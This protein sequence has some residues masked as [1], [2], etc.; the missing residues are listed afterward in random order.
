MDITQ[1]R[2]KFTEYFLGL[3]YVQ[4]EPSK[5]VPENDPS[6]LYTT[7]GMQQFKNFYTRPE[8]APASAIITTQPVMRTSDIAE[9]GDDTHLTM[10]EMLG[11]FRFGYAS[12]FKMKQDALQEA[13]Q[14]LT[15]ELNIEP[16]RLDFN[17]FAGDGDI[18][19]DTESEGILRSLGVK[20]RKSGREDTFW[21]PTGDEGPCGPAPEVYLD[22]VEIGTIV[23]NQYYQSAD[24]KIR[25]LE[26][27]GLDVG[28]GLERLAATLQGKSSIWEIEPFL[29]WTEML[30][31]A[32]KK[33]ARLIVDHL[34]AVIFV[35]SAGV[36]PGKNG[37]EYIPRRLLARI[38]E[39][40][41]NF[42]PDYSFL[43]VNANRLGAKISAY[44]LQA[45]YKLLPWR[46]TAKSIEW[47]II[48]Y[49][50]VMAKFERE[51]EG[52]VASNR[53][54]Q[55]SAEKF[56]F[57]QFTA[58]GVPI[59]VVRQK[60]ATNEV[61]LDEKHLAELIEKHQATS[62]SGAVGIFKGGLADHEA[63]TVKHHTTHHLLLAALR[64]VLGNSIV[65]RGSNV[66]SE[67]LRLDFNFD[68]K[69]T[70]EELKKVAAIVNEKIKAD[71]P[72]VCEEMTK[73][74]ALKFGALAEFGQKYGESVS[75]YSIGGFSK[76]LCG[77]PHVEKTGLLGRFEILKEEASS[78]GIRRIK[79]RVC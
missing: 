18:L 45:G 24:K 66:T 11:N 53:D 54:H 12:S 51:L 21:G 8:D 1:V 76:E 71:L 17:I 30:K 68:R 22:G 79:A 46:E 5:L 27:A 52:F 77:G 72:V 7:A 74:Q 19:P 14:F 73:G 69:L 26:K 33:S 37:R 4:G 55:A 3:G 35:L 47:E 40:A 75:V 20:P 44:Y 28:Y 29:G 34:K 49:G 10:F 64:Q 41:R 50:H 31:G 48:R 42:D 65:Q 70:P 6:V 25:P 32:D 56:V 60:L 36:K 16:A 59:E 67:R 38:F 62:R 9:V 78:Q 57:E 2:Q 23:L 39:A 61:K 15:E 58:Q 13:W 43:D 63:Q